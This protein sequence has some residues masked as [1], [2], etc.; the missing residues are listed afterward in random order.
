M[1]R[2][3]KSQI[4]QQSKDED[5]F[6]DEDDFQDLAPPVSSRKR[7]QSSRAQLYQGIVDDLGELL[8]AVGLKAA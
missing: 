2:L 1:L 6:E 4:F 5:E 7:E 3:F 8:Y